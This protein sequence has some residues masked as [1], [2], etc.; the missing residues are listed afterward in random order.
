MA[1][2]EAPRE[3]LLREATAL[4]ERIELAPREGSSASDQ[5]IVAGFRRDGAL[6][7]F[8]GEDPVY[9]FN[10]AGELRRAYREGQLFKAVQGRLV[11]MRRVRTEREA[12]LVRHDLSREEEAEFLCQMNERLQEIGMDLT[13]NQFT[14][15]GQVPDNADVLSRVKAALS[16]RDNR[17]IAK[18]PNA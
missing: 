13:N 4:V 12:Q 5:H 14:I 9:Q 15:V 16:S 3:D 7:I 8:F 10:A 6:S 18:Q 1:R 2:D 17:A 11:A